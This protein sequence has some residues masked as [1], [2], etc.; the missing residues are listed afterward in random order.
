MDKKPLADNERI[1]TESDYL[2][3]HLAESFADSSTGGIP[4]D[5]T[6]LIKF[7]GAYLQDDRDERLARKKAGMEKAWSFMLRVRLPGGRVLP[8]QWLVFDRLSSRY[9]NETLKITTR[10]ALQLHGILKSEFKETLQEI[11]RVTLDTIATCGDVNRNVMSTPNPHVSSA[12]AE[13]YALASRL[14]SELLPRMRAYHEI[15]LDEE[16]IMGGPVE[17]EPLYG[18]TYLPRKFKIAVA[19]PP[20]NDVDAY[21]N[22]LSFIAV[23]RDGRVEGYN[24]TVGGGMGCS[25][26]NPATYPRLGDTIGFCTPDQVTAVARNVLLVQRDHGDRTDRKH[27]RLKYTIDDH[28][29][30]WFVRTLTEYQGFAL[31]P[32]RECSFETTGDTYAENDGERAVFVEGGRVSDRPGYLLRTAL[33]EIAEIHQGEFYLTPN[34]NLIIANIAP[35]TLEAIDAIIARHRLNTRHSGMRL[36]SIA[37]TSLPT[38]PLALAESERYLPGLLSSVEDALEQ[39]DLRDEPIVTRM[40]GC[41]NGCAR[42]Y[43]A[44]LAFVGKAPGKYNVL[45]GGS[46]RGDRLAYSLREGV[47]DTELPD[48]IKNLLRLFA[49]TRLLDER[50]GDWAVRVREDLK[51]S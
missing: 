19:V 39:Y 45:V 14:S 9:G 24:V 20:R 42:P 34:Q 26:N 47:R 48:L 27:A 8:E 15:W 7:H 25:H 41:P 38:C 43:V 21:T 36:S 37:C 18:K 6:Q 11:N 5:E 1:K 35:A 22:D 33:R 29:L 13:A 28:G 44:E 10:Q 49:E 23:V 12:H 32:A 16:R 3:G 40:T 51:E 30:D 46:A 50:F 17:E 31:E 4:E 2:R